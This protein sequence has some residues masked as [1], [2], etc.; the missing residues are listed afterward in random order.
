MQ[1]IIDSRAGVPLLPR[2]H[3]ADL[4]T[5]AAPAPTPRFSLAEGIQLSRAV[6]AA[7]SPAGP[8]PAGTRIRLSPKIEVPHDFFMTFGQLQR[9][10][11]VRPVELASHS[12]NL[13]RAVGLA[14]RATNNPRRP[15]ASTCRPA[16][17]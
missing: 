3:P 15:R 9:M 1:Q 5:T 14:P 4:S 6:V 17:R 13:P 16:A 10:G 8:T 7:S 2:P 12:T 11:R